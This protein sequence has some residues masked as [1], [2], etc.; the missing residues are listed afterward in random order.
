M[1]EL[2]IQSTKKTPLV[3]IKPEEGVLLMGGMSCSENAGAFYQP[4]LEFLT[5]ERVKKIKTLEFKFKYFN[6]SSAK[7]ILDVLEN[8]ARINSIGEDCTVNWYYE[9]DDEEM[10]DSGEIFGQ[11][12]E[13]E[14]NFVEAE[15]SE[16]EIE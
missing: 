11:M 8:F 4:I 16:I 13:V 14:F 1:N 6:T 3:K 7:C 2:I 15:E 5:E 10:Q 12:L 9:K